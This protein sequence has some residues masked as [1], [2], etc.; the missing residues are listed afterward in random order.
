MFNSKEN[1]FSLIEL[2]IVLIITAILA[3][4]GFILKSQ[5]L[6]EQL[7]DK[8][9]SFK[10]INVTKYIKIINVFSK[11]LFTNIISTI[12]KKTDA[13]LVKSMPVCSTASHSSVNSSPTPIIPKS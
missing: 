7:L 4:L 6:L 12:A 9:L 13:R 3:Q 8:L 11:P 5:N 1:G 10:T 2:I